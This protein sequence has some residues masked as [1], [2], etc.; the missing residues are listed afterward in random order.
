MAKLIKH[1]FVNIIQ[2]DIEECRLNYLHVSVESFDSSLMLHLNG[3]VIP[4][5]HLECSANSGSR[6]CS[7]ARLR[8]RS[9]SRL[10]IGLD[11]DLDQFSI[12]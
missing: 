11:I 3:K 10:R 9:R 5:E 7:G 8:S 12:S 2:P 1:A 4:Y 6:L